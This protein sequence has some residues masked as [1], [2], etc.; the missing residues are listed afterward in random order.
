[1]TFANPWATFGVL[2][3]TL[4]NLEQLVRRPLAVRRP[5]FLGPP[6]GC[7][8][9]SGGSA[10]FQIPDSI[11]PRPLPARLPPPPRTFSKERCCPPP[12]QTAH[13][14]LRTPGQPSAF[15]WNLYATLGNFWGPL[16]HPGRPLGMLQQRWATVGQPVGNPRASLGKPQQS[17]GGLWLLGSLGPPLIALLLCLALGSGRGRGPKQHTGGEMRVRRVAGPPPPVRADAGSGESNGKS[18]GFDGNSARWCSAVSP[19]IEISIFIVSDT[20]PLFHSQ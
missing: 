3:G 13:F 10:R 5:T 20:S 17:P 11:P 8:R 15:L 19:T 16:G 14:R 1:M 2:V 7:A 6:S 18:T 12:P 9:A 4:R